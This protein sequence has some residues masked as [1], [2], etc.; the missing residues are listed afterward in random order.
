MSG[1]YP[2]K[3]LSLALKCL[4]AP[5]AKF[6]THEG[7]E[8]V[9]IDLLYKLIINFNPYVAIKLVIGTVISSESVRNDLSGNPILV[10]LFLFRIIKNLSLE[11]SDFF[12]INKCTI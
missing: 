12:G 6:K 10:N 5:E 3:L 9:G 11:S 8:I 4:N 1:K 2:I 7:D